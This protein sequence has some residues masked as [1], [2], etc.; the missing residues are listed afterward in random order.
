MRK[1]LSIAVL[2]LIIIS[3][4]MAVEEVEYETIKENEVYE[5]STMQTLQIILAEGLLKGASSVKNL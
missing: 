2:G 5:V 1:I 3:N 4:A